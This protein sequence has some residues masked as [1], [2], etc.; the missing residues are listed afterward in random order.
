M[1]RML[2]HSYSIVIYSYHNPMTGYFA[3]TVIVLFDHVG[4]QKKAGTNSEQSSGGSYGL[5]INMHALQPELAESSLRQ[6]EILRQNWEEQ[7]KSQ[8][9]KEE[10]LGSSSVSSNEENDLSADKMAE[11]KSSSDLS[12][13]TSVKSPTNHNIL[14]PISLLQ[15][16][17]ADDLPETVQMSFGD[18][19]V[20]IGERI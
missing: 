6:I 1:N 16:M 20:R 4:E 15:A 13:S 5:I 11:K 9:E 8:F 18:S 3:K 10:S 7:K 17:N 14:R 2:L 19:P 12:R